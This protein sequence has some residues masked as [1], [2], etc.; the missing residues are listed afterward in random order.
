MELAVSQ[1]TASQGGVNSAWSPALSC[2]SDNPNCQRT[3]REGEREREREA[4][5]EN[6]LSFRDTLLITAAH[7]LTVG[8]QTPVPSSLPRLSLSSY[9]QR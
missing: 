7:R 3:E 5:G 1:K 6:I 2:A 4:E 8:S 9:L